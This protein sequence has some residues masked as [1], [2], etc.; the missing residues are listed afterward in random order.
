MQVRYKTTPNALIIYREKWGT[1]A[2]GL[3]MGLVCVAFGVGFYGLMADHV[4]ESRPFFRVFCGVFVLAGLAVLVRLPGQARQMM[5]DDGLHILVADAQGIT[6]SPNLGAE[7]RLYPW[8]DIEDIVL[9]EKLRIIESDETSY[10][11]RS[12]V[13]FLPMEAFGSASW[14]KLVTAGISLSGARRPFVLGN[15][16]RG[17]ASTI[18]AA[19]RRFAPSAVLVSVKA[20]VV[21]DKKASV[22][23][24]EVV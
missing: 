10:L 23:T 15:F 5:A 17:Q 16:P 19:L 8:G 9:A 21:F 3:L 4:G 24:D 13:I 14:Y 18:Q 6:L 11:W 20:R 12:V 2:L 7:P 1:L 22:D